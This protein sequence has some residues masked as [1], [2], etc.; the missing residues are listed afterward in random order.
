M[1]RKNKRCDVQKMQTTVIIKMMTSE[2]FV[3]WCFYTIEKV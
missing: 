1:G 2:V 3:Q